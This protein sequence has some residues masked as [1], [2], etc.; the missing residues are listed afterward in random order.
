MRVGEPLLVAY[1]MGDTDAAQLN[2]LATV[3]VDCKSSYL[4]CPYHLVVKVV[5]LKRWRN[6]S[7]IPEDFATIY[8]AAEFRWKQD[9]LPESFSVYFK[10]VWLNEHLC[11][12]QCHLT[13]S[14]LATANNPVEQFNWAFKR[15]YT[16]HRLLK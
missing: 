3:F 8:T 1:V 4:M 11:R 5:E 15:D 10:H 7:M 13:P 16:G 6:N 12:W 2:T 14:G 9:H